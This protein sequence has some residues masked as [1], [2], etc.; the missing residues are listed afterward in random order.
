[1]NALLAV[2]VKVEGD[3]NIGDISLTK[4]KKQFEMFLD[5]LM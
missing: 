1:M 5:K 4:D 3:I 2:C